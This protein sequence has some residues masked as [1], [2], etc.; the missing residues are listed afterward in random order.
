MKIGVVGA[1]GRMGKNHIIAISENP[2]VQLTAALE[3]E[4]SPSI[5][6]DA[7]IIAGLEESSVIIESDIESFLSKVD[8]IIDFS[9][10]EASLNL[11]KLA[12][13]KSVAHI[14]GT[15]GL[16]SQQENE[17]NEIAK[18]GVIIY[19]PNMSVGV[20]LLFSLT[21]KVAS[22]L[23]EDYDIEI[24]EMHHK[25]K[26]DSP[27]GTA[28]GLGRAAAKGRQVELDEVAC[29]ERNGIIGER[30]SGEIG[31]A[32]IRGGDV[33]GD[34]TVIFA[35]EGERIELTHKA[36]SRSIFS[37]GAVRACLWSKDQP[38]GLY[39]MHDVLGL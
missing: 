12:V 16:T 19:A 38:N 18:Q 4:N 39:S 10:P 28:L 5:G 22:I 27:S 11:A 33:V 3:R 9:N 15:T 32:T 2:E 1:S 21:Q 14:I 30:P 8:A 6:K 13:E 25:K 20:N 29:K 31:F 34:H 23:A 24:V 36:S 35:S 37:K 7:G 17:L 26:V